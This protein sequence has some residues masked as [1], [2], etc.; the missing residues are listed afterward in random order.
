MLDLLVENG[1]GQ[2]KPNSAIILLLHKL[3]SI[4]KKLGIESDELVGLLAQA[5]CHAPASLDQV[6]F[7]QLVTSG[8]LAKGD[9]K[10]LSKFVGQVI[11]NTLRRDD[12]HSQSS[13]P[14]IY[15]VSGLQHH[16]PLHSRPRSP[17][18]S[19]PVASTSNV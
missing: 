4:F 13:S 2:P 9:E 15:C 19:K 18:F 3:F 16:P 10:P 11:L 12:K 1:A 5:A 6:V 7:D 8:I 14:F 17:Y